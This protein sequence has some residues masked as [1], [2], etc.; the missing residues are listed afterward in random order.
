MSNLMRGS[1]VECEVIDVGGIIAGRLLGSITG[2]NLDPACG[3]P[4]L[5]ISG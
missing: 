2:Q 1:L 4:A 5:Y 3:L